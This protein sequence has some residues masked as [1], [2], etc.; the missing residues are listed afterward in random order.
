LS[1]DWAE[2]SGGCELGLVQ[3]TPNVKSMLKNKADVRNL[4]VSSW[5]AG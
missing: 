3:A 1:D 5:T 4:I 2:L